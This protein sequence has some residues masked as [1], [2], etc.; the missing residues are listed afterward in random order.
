MY[1]SSHR[2]HVSCSLT[3]VFLSLSS[4][5][6][7]GGDRESDPVT[8]TGDSWKMFHGLVHDPWR[9]LWSSLVTGNCYLVVRS[10]FRS[11]VSMYAQ[12]PCREFNPELLLIFVLKWYVSPFR[13]LWLRLSYSQCFCVP[14]LYGV[15]RPRVKYSYRRWVPGRSYVILVRQGPPVFGYSSGKRHGRRYYKGES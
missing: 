12:R 7:R 1:V 11:V 3:V 2:S 4:R 8:L 15:E 14:A 10:P 9:G 13:W 6:W 5:D